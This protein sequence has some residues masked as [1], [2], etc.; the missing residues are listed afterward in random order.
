L[1]F[2][3]FSI[4]HDG[5]DGRELLSDVTLVSNRGVVLNRLKIGFIMIVVNSIIKAVVL[6]FLLR[7]VLRRYLL[8]PFQK[9]VLKVNK[10][11]LDTI[12]TTRLDLHIK[13][14]NEIGILQKSF[15]A[16]LSKIEGQKEHILAVE[17]EARAELEEKVRE[18]TERLRH[19]EQQLHRAQKM[20]AIG[21][22]AG[23]VAHDLNNIL[24]GILGYP[25]L[26]LLKLP[27]AS[28]L[29]KPIE[30]IQASGQ[31]A[32][33]IVADLLT[34]ARGVATRQEPLDLNV[35]VAE[36]LES[37][38]CRTPLLLHPHITCHTSLR[39]ENAIISCSSIHIKKTVMNLL[40]NGME[41]VGA[42]GTVKITT[43]NRQVSKE[44][45][46]EHGLLA[47]DY[48][49][50]RVED[51]GHGI[52]EDDL[53]HIFEPFYSKKVM[54]RS[55]TGLGLA[56]VWNTVHDHKGQ[57]FVDSSKRGTCFKLYFPLCD[58][59]QTV[60]VG[61]DEKPLPI[62]SSERI[63]VVDDEPQVRDLA[64]Q[65]LVI[66][67]YRVDVVRSGEEALAFL[68]KNEVDLVVLDMM[69]DPGMS[70][71]QTYG[72]IVKL[73]PG[74]KA[75]IAS[76][77][78]ESDDVKATLALG[79]QGFIHKPYLMDQLGTAVKEALVQS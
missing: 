40:N 21:M 62:G 34:V 78:S 2:Y 9:F 46:V 42:E 15:N 26:L 10:I 16:M 47:G 54:G 68:E 39:A 57:I 48:V 30:E 71:R 5:L 76:G 79:A 43:E 72:E 65:M 38:E 49:V 18:R 75:I 53:E 33:N 67:G 63:L 45:A 3:T 14:D 1:F 64:S 32:A 35:L 36:F 27:E 8:F 69:M 55:G 25:E 44:D 31:R 74:Q 41:A 56:I 29:R 52:A 77:F 13:D 51:N 20:E 11:D 17:S 50:L 60:A 4:T 73:Y 66:L 12:G 58:H 70:G 24:T 28:P 22:M 19:S 61:Q 23:G 37:P 6:W 7:W 59:Q